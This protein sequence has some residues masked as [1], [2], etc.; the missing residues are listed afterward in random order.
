[1]HSGRGF[2][3]MTVIMSTTL[4]TNV[5]FEIEVILVK[6]RLQIGEP[7]EVKVAPYTPFIW[8]YIPERNQTDDDDE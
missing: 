6:N 5:S 2:G 4:P 7:Q 3:M 1:M 8:K